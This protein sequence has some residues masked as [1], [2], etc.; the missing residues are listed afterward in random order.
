MSSDGSLRKSEGVVGGQRLKADAW[1]GA[2]IQTD[3][4]LREYWR[5]FAVACNTST[6]T[7]ISFN[8]M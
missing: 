8:T 2:L 6:G 3:M 4:I 5:V 1:Q 7:S